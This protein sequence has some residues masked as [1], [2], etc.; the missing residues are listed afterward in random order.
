M[1]G[2]DTDDVT[3]TGGSK[4]AFSGSAKSYAL[5]VT[6][7]GSA[8]VVVTVRANAAT[9]GANQGPA[10]PATAYGGLGRHRTGGARFQPGERHHGHGTPR[11]TSRSP[12]TSRSARPARGRRWPTPTSR[13]S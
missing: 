10:S 4:G 5:A 3:V 11:P 6:P 1:T 7:A 8:D 13:G 2:F 9:D 12:S